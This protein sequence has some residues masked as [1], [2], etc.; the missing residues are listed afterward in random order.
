[1]CVCRVCVCVRNH[2][3]QS[4]FCSLYFSTKCEALC[5]FGR[6][7]VCMCV[8]AFARVCMCVCCVSVMCVLCVCVCVCV[9]V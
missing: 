7:C 2:S 6:V 3:L 1:M 8:S 9:C 4:Y 5:V